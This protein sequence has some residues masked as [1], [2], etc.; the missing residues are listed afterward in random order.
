MIEKAKSAALEAAVD[1]AIVACE[2]DLP[3][4][5]RAIVIAN[6]FLTENNTALSQELDY[7][8]RAGS[9]PVSRARSLK[10]RMTSGEP[11]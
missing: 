7:A 11:E 4:A 2:G 5:I 8:W 10:P 3:A 1:A 9:R 6:N